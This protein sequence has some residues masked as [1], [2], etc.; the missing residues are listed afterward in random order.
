WLPYKPAPPCRIASPTQAWLLRHCVS[1]ST[2]LHR[3][4]YL[5]CTFRSTRSTGSTSGGASVGCLPHCGPLHF[6]AERGA[7]SRENSRASAVLA[8]VSQA[9]AKQRMRRHDRIGTLLKSPPK[10]KAA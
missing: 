2:P 9:R 4:R 7:N 10:S 1:L 8:A 5:L 6:G 3:V